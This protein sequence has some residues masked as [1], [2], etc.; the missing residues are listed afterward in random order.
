MRFLKTTKRP[1][2]RSLK[3]LCHENKPKSSKTYLIGFISSEK[4]EVIS[5]FYNVIVTNNL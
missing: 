3:W 4:H 5:L 1:A 2:S